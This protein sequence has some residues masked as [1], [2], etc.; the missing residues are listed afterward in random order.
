MCM[1]VC[2]HVCMCVCMCVAMC[3]YVCM[4]YGR[5]WSTSSYA[6]IPM[7]FACNISFL[8]ILSFSGCNDQ[9]EAVM[10]RDNYIVSITTAS[11]R[12][13]FCRGHLSW[14]INEYVQICIGL[15]RG[16]SIQ[17]FLK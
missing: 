16:L 1:C 12:N 9:V 11:S 3:M 8:H 17:N 5:L 2:V 6:L 4:E 10:Q 14:Q 13:Q 15:D 7:T